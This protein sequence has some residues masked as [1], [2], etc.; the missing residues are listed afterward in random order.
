MSPAPTLTAEAITAITATTAHSGGHIS[1]DGGGT[2]TAYGVCWNK[3]GAPT[4]ADAHTDDFGVGGISLSVSHADIG[5]QVTITGT[6]FGASQGTSTVTFGEPLNEQGWAP[7]TKP[8][9]SYVSWGDTSIVVTVPSMSPGKA[10]EAGTYHRV[11]VYVG[12][13]ASGAADF[14]ID[15]VTVNPHGTGSM[16]AAIT[17]TSNGT[18]YD[19]SSSDTNGVFPTAGSDVLFDGCTFTASSAVI[20]GDSAGVV[21]LGAGRTHQRITFLNCTIENNTGSGGGS[22]GVGVNGFKANNWGGQYCDD[23]SFVDCLFGTPNSGASAFSRMGY[24]QVEDDTGWNNAVHRVLFRGCTFEPVADEPISN[25]RGDMMQL[26]DDCTFKGGGNNSVNGWTFILE[27]NT[28]AYVEIRGSHFWSYR[29]ALFNINAPDTSDHHIL[30]TG[31]DVDFGHVY[32]TDSSTNSDDMFF[33][34]QGSHI[35]IADFTINAGTADHCVKWIGA[36]NS[37]WGSYYNW[38]SCVSNDFTGSTVTG[39]VGQAGP[40]IPSTKEGYWESPGNIDASNI[41]PEKI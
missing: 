1:D 27:V 25:N 28:G 31:G 4:I 11:R 41:L 40:G 3:T 9:A 23:L 2:I 39:Y 6:G 37:G 36:A 17:A 12:G 20:P 14:Y 18:G 13:V 7:V 8:A 15:P 35:R 33:F 30:I 22:S 24:E 38:R 34:G 16:M 5:D 29:G 19:Y 26:V 21:T 32:Q 10:G